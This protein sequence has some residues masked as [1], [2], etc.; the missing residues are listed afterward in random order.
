M[1]PNPMISVILY[2]WCDERYP[3][4]AATKLLEETIGPP[5]VDREPEYFS[6][7]IDNQ[8]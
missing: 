7:I 1:V 4:I 5:G 2:E 3:N 6:I 8:V